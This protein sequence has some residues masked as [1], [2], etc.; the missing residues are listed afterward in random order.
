MIP[1]TLQIDRPLLDARTVAEGFRGN[2]Q[3][4]CDGHDQLQGLLRVLYPAYRIE[5]SYAVSGTFPWSSPD[6]ERDSALVDGLFEDNDAGLAMERQSARTTDRIHPRERYGDESVPTVVLGHHGDEARA[7]DVLPTRLEHERERARRETETLRERI[8]DAEDAGDY[9][10]ARRLRHRL[11][12]DDGGDP[13][14][15]LR[16]TY[17][18]PDAVGAD[19]F[20]SVERVD[21]VFLPFWIAEWHLALGVVCLGSV[22]AGSYLRL[23]E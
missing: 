6:H 1:E 17:G 15:E 12:T 3:T 10:E 21:R 11:Q 16:D 8:G 22:V 18:L 7:A 4:W 9:T 19:S 14:S 13:L 5:Y 23:T 20:E 2:D